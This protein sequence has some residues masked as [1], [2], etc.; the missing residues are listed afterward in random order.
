MDP[1]TFLA[2]PAATSTDST[3]P[4]APPTA[5]PIGAIAGALGGRDV[6]TIGGENTPTLDGAARDGLRR[7][8]P[9]SITDNLEYGGLLY[10][11]PQTGRYGATAPLKGTATGFDPGAACIPPGTRLTG[12]YHTHG[13]YSRAA[14]DGSAVRTGSAKRDDFNSDRFSEP[15]YRGI[16]TDARGQSEYAGF[17]GTPSNKNLKFDPATGATSS[18]RPGLH[19]AAGGA[20][21]GGAAA[22]IGT[23]GDAIVHGQFD[24][25]TLRAVA[26]NGA[27]GAVLGAA[28]TQVE[29][30]A[31][32]GLDRVAGPAVERLATSGFGAEA[33]ALG[34]TAATR[35]GGAGVAGAAIGIGVSVYEN[36]DGLAHGDSHAI[37]NVAG[38]AVVGTGSALAGAAAG[39][40]IGSVIPVAGT[41]VGAGV[42]LVAGYAADKIMRAGGVD[43]W[44]GNEV[45]D[46]VD[47]V[48]HFFSS[49]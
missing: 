34:R 4:A 48:K 6:I 37:G 46:G 19:A 27:G 22:A 10:H 45:T 28:A 43:H 33:G 9:K 49:L 41:I 40:A 8:K 13:D 5:V 12:D 17:L 2:A 20:L 11:D 26:Q 44:I 47:A 42:G 18:I 31:T 38:D 39:A 24:R 3:Q 32:A 16:R 25:D 15:D 36:R 14:A 35:V 21:F 30:A 23:A 29:R 7:A 1:I